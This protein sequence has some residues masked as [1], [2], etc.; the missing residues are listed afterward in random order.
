MI[1]FWNKFEKSRENLKERYGMLE[2]I[3]LLDTLGDL[4]DHGAEI[5]VISSATGLPILGKKEVGLQGLQGVIEEAI[6]RLEHY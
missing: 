1:N 3:I 4:D 6:G 5:E 2:G